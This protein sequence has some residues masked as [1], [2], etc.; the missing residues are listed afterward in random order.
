MGLKV[1][2]GASITAGLV[3]LIDDSI[4][5]ATVPKYVV[6]DRGGQFQDVFR[7]AM[8]ERGICHGRGQPQAWQFNAKVERLFWSL[9]RWWRVSLVEPNVTAIQKRL[10]AYASWH[11]LFRPHEAL[12]R[13]TP[14]E[15]AW[16]VSLPEPLRYTEGGELEPR[17]TIR[18]LHVGGDPQLLYPVIKVKPRHRSAA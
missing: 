13:L 12:G 10:D 11:N 6:T 2:Q 1:F 4:E 14:S 18:R 8:A 7:A 15:A 16:G 3:N 5:R 17:I 9:K